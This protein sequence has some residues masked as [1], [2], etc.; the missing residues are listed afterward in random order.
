MVVEFQ[1]QRAAPSHEDLDNWVQQIEDIK[2]W[3]LN[4]QREFFPKIAVQS[5]E[6]LPQYKKYSLA[7]VFVVLENKMIVLNS[8]AQWASSFIG[9]R[10]LQMLVVNDPRVGPVIGKVNK[11]ISMVR[12]I[13]SDVRAV[14][15]ARM[16]VED[17]EGELT[18]LRNGWAY[19]EHLVAQIKTVR[20]IFIDTMRDKF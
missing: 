2:R 8:F 20:K 3:L 19:T 18:L 10:V 7:Q 13:L 9:R 6:K 5:S 14:L 15:G 11:L 12:A 1:V 16:A 17:D 4:F